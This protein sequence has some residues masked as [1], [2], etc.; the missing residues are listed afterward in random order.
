MANFVV[1]LWGDWTDNQALRA[2]W[3]NL[4]NWFGG[5]TGKQAEVKSWTA[6]A[7]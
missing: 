5:S 7:D 1:W 6:S 2:L 3:H 4:G